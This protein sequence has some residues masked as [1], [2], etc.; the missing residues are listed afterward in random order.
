MAT[1][2]DPAAAKVRKSPKG[3][4]RFRDRDPR[5][6]GILGVAICALLIFVS[7]TYNKV[8]WIMGTHD[9]TAYV[10]DA[11]GLKNGDEVHVAGMRVGTVRD[12]KIE[13]GAVRIDFDINRDVELG[14]DTRAQ[15]KTDSLLGRRALAVFS[16][17]SGELPDRTIPLD[18]TSTPYALTDALGDV[19]KTVEELDT[20]QVSEALDQISETMDAAGPEVRGALDGITRLSRTLNDRDEELKELLRKASES[21]DVLGKRSDQFSQLI[22]DGNTLFTALDERKR[23]I[24]DLIRNVDALAIQLSGLVQD[25]EAQLGPALDKVEK[26]SDQLIRNKDNIDLGLRR[27]GPYSTP[28]G[29]AVASGPWF[30]AYISNLSLPHYTQSLFHDL[31]PALDPNT[32]PQPPLER[33]PTMPGA[34]EINILDE[35]PGWGEG[36][37]P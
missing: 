8:G 28:L 5:W 27:M 25:N 22:N 11:A 30:N 23:A 36:R 29:E 34:P 7:T 21:T 4:L 9:A 2:K 24:A 31:A 1:K 35:F 18:R 20:D 13:N 26:V 6:I 33:E 37:T 17:G 3:K 14:A 19:S 10:A 12:L 32:G 16:G 15:I